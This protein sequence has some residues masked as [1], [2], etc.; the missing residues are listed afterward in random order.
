LPTSHAGF[1]YWYII[2][3]DADY[4]LVAGES[5]QPFAPII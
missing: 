1:S 3:K 5:T 4:H 2:Y